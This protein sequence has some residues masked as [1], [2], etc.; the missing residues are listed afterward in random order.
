MRPPEKEN[1]NE[2]SVDNESQSHNGES[3]NEL[4]EGA[5]KYRAYSVYYSE[6]YHYVSNGRDSQSARN[7]SLEDKT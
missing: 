2:G 5:E 4:H 7:V 1:S 3:P 6:A